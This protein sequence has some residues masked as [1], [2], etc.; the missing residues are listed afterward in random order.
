MKAG[1]F[2]ITLDRGHGGWPR[3]VLSR[4]P[5]RGETVDDAMKSTGDFAR[6]LRRLKPETHVLRFF[7]W[8]DSFAAYLKVRE[9][10]GEQDY[11]AGWEPMTTPDEYRIVLGTYVLGVKPPPKPQAPPV[12]NQKPAAPP[13]VLD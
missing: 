7:V 13:N 5:G 10:A 3:M 4:I 11:A 9:M 6:T 1:A 2:E 8:P 12:P